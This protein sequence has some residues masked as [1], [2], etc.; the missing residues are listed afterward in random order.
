MAPSVWHDVL[1]MTLQ[2]ADCKLL[3]ADRV[4]YWHRIMGKDAVCDEDPM[5][6]PDGHDQVEDAVFAA[7]QVTAAATLTAAIGETTSTWHLTSGMNT[8]SM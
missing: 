6:Q 2:G 1:L 7:A 3:Q 5:G 4:T 8:M